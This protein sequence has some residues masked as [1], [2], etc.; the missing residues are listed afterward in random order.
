[1][2]ERRTRGAL[3]LTHR[4]PLVTGITWGE[5]CP[6]GFRGE[7]PSDQRPDDGRSLCFD[8]APL[9]APM[10]LLGAPLA[11]LK[12]AV[13]EPIA[14]IAARLCDVAP[15]GSS[16]LMSYGILN[17]ARREGHGRSE[18]MPPGK[19]LS[20]RL[21]LNDIGERVAAG[22]RLRL[23][24]STGYWPMVWPSPRPVT[25]TLFVPESAL[26]LP[27]RRPPTADT[28]LP[29]FAPPEMAPPVALTRTRQ[30]RRE[31]G[32]HENPT[33]GE[34]VFTIHRDRGAYRLRD[35]DLTV[36]GGAVERFSITEGDPLS[37]K[38]DIAWR[39][40]MT[41][42]DWDIRTES[43]TVLT[44]SKDTFHLRASLDGFEG[45]SRVFTKNWSFDIPRDGV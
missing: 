17:L 18:P 22:H 5:W 10:D 4:S 43:R 16:R 29:D 35:I 20:V 42:G 44:A 31:R 12:L 38:G 15:D 25:L 21:Q 37:A 13:T 39:Y 2:L 23:A 19:P 14:L 6:Y 26:E 24:I 34:T 45:E 30:G 40:R 9:A 8:S 41:R 33:T 1:L 36:D 3:R 27:V 11:E 28:S 7:L 32:V